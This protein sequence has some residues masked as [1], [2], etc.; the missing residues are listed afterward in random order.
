MKIYNKFQSLLGCF[1]LAVAVFFLNCV[2]V[3]QPINA[4]DDHEHSHEIKESALEGVKKIKKRFPG[5]GK[6]SRLFA[7][8]GK[9][10][11]EDGRKE[12]IYSIAVKNNVKIEGCIACKYFFKALAKGSRPSSSHK[13]NKKKPKSDGETP[14]ATPKPIYKQRMPNIEV[15][16]LA[17]Q[18]GKE[19]FEDK[20]NTEKSYRALEFF[21]RLLKVKNEFSPA[22]RH[23]LDLLMEAFM[24]PFQEY[25]EKLE[26]EHRDELKDQKS[27]SFI[28]RDKQADLESLFDFK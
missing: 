26:R 1:N 15:I 22:E 7:E 27:K 23:Y 21:E 2:F 16:S 20:K 10:L 18:I 28:E 3:I 8:L 17:T 25:R 19:L 13:K 6:Y 5:Y 14:E 4:Q 9:G 11:E 12:F 24:A